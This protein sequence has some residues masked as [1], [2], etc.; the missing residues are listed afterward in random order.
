[1][2]SDV[3]LGDGTS[4]F[5]MWLS[6]KLTGATVYN[7]TC[8]IFEGWSVKGN[9]RRPNQFALKWRALGFLANKRRHP[10]VC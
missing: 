3:D 8:I 7:S 10:Q 4:G 1:M 2:T 9:D 6:N 5:S